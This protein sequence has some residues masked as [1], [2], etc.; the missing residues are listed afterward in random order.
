MSLQERER[1]AIAPEQHV[2]AVVD[3]LARFAIVERRRA[4]TEPAAGFEDEHA[5]AVLRQAHCRAEPGES[6]ADDN[7]VVVVMSATTIAASR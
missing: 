6:G 5:R 2:L 4:S 3:E 7:R 1:V